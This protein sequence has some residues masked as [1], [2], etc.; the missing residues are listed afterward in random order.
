MESQRKIE[1]FVVGGGGTWG[2]AYAGAVEG[3]FQSD[4]FNMNDY[5][6]IKNYI[7]TSIGSI[8]TT[9]MACGASPKELQELIGEVDPSKAQD[10]SWGWFRDLYRLYYEFGWY[11]GEYLE[12]S[13]KKIINKLF[14]NE[15]KRNGSK[16]GDKKDN[17]TFQDIYTQFGKNLIVNGVNVNTRETVYFNRLTHPDMEVSIACRISSGLPLIFKAYKYQNDYYVDGGVVDTYPIR[18]CFTDMFE[19]LNTN[20]K[21][22]QEEITKARNE[23]E[24][25]IR[26][27]VKEDVLN[28]TV[29]IKGYDD[30]TFN[31]VV[32]GKSK[33]I[34]KFTLIGF[35]REIMELMMDM[36]ARQY[37][38]ANMWDRTIKL[39]MGT[40]S[41]ADFDLTDDDKN[42]LINIGK[43]GAIQF[44]SQKSILR[45]IVSHDDI[46]GDVDDFE[47]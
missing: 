39:N 47:K 13:V 35:I 27:K 36:G 17:F 43:D 30:R 16:L 3:L 24:D 1:N 42:K 7:G 37:I 4:T 11:K 29:G 34:E 23:T 2:Y 25:L 20:E 22:T 32:Y 6:N 9:M 5:K 12:S 38:D 45:I 31:Y 15:F 21:Y 41:V 8:I 33:R 18:Y 26:D 28:K 46:D 10:D 14:D 44:A 40:E 19:M